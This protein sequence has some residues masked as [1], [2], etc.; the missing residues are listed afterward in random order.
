MSFADLFLRF[1][2]KTLQMLLFL[3]Y[4]NFLVIPYGFVV[5]T[6]KHLIS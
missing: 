4:L 2:I 1:H 3:F 5:N 6:A